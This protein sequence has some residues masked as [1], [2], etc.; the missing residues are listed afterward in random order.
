MAGLTGDVVTVNRSLFTSAGVGLLMGQ[1]ACPDPI[2]I[3]IAA[4][5]G[6]PGDKGLRA[7]LQK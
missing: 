3:T 6:E 2:S 4:A 5:C 1:T 7:I